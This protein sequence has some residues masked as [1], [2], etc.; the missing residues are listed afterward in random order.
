MVRLI[1]S[2]DWFV[3]ISSFDLCERRK[4][5]RHLKIDLYPMDAGTDRGLTFTS[6]DWPSEPR[7]PLY[8][9]SPRKPAHSASSFFYTNITSLPPIARV[10]LTKIA[11]YRRKG[12]ALVIKQERN[13]II[14]DN[15]DV[16]NSR[17]DKGD[18]LTDRAISQGKEATR[19]EIE[20]AKFKT[21]NGGYKFN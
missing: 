20:S 9:L 21:S 2:P 8:R 17:E 4:W 10:Y 12:K 1:P 15:Q 5:K 19:N 16:L 6:P 18:K 13:L 11:E 3:G 7:E 14:Y